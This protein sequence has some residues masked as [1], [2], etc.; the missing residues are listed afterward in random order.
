MLKKRDEEFNE[1]LNHC[2]ELETSSDWS[3]KFNPSEIQWNYP[4]SPYEWDDILELDED[5]SI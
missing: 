5:Q 1:V 2:H 4:S 3:E